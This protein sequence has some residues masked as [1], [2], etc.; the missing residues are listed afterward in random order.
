VAADRKLMS[1]DVIIKRYFKENLKNSLFI[2]KYLKKKE[3][4]NPKPFRMTGRVPIAETFE[5][6]FRFC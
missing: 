3:V 1:D 5:D 6:L 4:W 2:C